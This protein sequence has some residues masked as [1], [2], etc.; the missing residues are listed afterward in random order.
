MENADLN[1]QRIKDKKIIVVGMGKSGQ[2]VV[3]ALKEIGSEI[4]IQDSNP[5]ENMKPAIISYIEKAEIPAYFGSFPKNIEDFDMMVLSP[6]VSLE[7]EIVKEAI[8]KGVEVIGELELAYRLSKGRYIAITGTN[9]KTTTTTLVGEI[10]K[11]ANKRAY[12]VGNIGNPA[13][14]DALI[15]DDEDWFISEVSSFQLETVDKFKPFIS[16]ILNFTPDHLNRH[17]TM[18]AYGMAKARIFANQNSGDYLII[19]KDDTACYKLSLNAKTNIIPFSRKEKLGKGAYLDDGFIVIKD[20]NGNEYEICK[21]DDI[22]IP[23]NHNI[24]NILAASAIS[25]FAGIKPEVIREAIKNFSGVEHR[26]E[27]S[28]EVDGVKFYNDSKGTNVD[29]SIIALRAL[30][31]NIILI[32]G[33]DGKG[34][35]FKELAKNLAG[36]VKAVI[37]YG[38]DAGIIE[39]DIIEENFSEVYL[40]K[41]LP[42]SVSKAFKISKEGDKIL[43]S[44]AC[45]SWDMYDSY[46]QRGNHFKEC[47]NS[48]LK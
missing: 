10:F 2:A 40:E 48:L 28:G 29:A 8:R 26:I 11:E 18:E 19:N 27:Y 25:F 12:V 9:G 24:E 4:S 21:V 33:G 5:R 3:K 45:A 13:I 16:A 36:R 17:H 23:G 22:K 14:T 1:M 42:N 38:R 15:S 39:K 37:L 44:P 41:D 43:L 35:D 7:L 46:I 30:K 32:A 34:Q 47:V 20:E 31:N 6:G